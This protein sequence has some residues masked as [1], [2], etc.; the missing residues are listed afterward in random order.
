MKDI[1]LEVEQSQV[2]FVSAATLEDRLLYDD[3]FVD[4]FNVF[5]QL[6]VFGTA[7]RYERLDGYYLDTPSDISNDSELHQLVDEQGKFLQQ[8]AISLWIK[9]HRLPFFLRSRLFLEY[10]LCKLLLRKLSET[11]R[12]Q[13][14]RL[15]LRGY[16]SLSTPMVPPDSPEQWNDSPV[17]CASQASWPG[18]PQERHY[19]RPLGSAS[20]LPAMLSIALETRLKLLEG[21]PGKKMSNGDNDG[22]G[23]P[24][25]NSESYLSQDMFDDELNYAERWKIRSAGG[26]QVNSYRKRKSSLFTPSCETR[27]GNKRGR[28]VRR[29]RSAP[30]EGL[31]ER[32][33][34]EE[35]ESEIFLNDFSEVDENDT[36]LCFD[37]ADVERTEAELR[38]I[39]DESKRNLQEIKED[40]LNSSCGMREFREFLTGTSGLHLFNFWLDVEEYKDLGE[41][42]AENENTLQM[43]RVK[44]FREINDKYKTHLTGEAK[45]KIREALNHEGL[46]KDLFTR[47]QYDTLR[48]LRSYWIPRF[49]VHKEKTNDEMFSESSLESRQSDGATTL[50]FLPKISF[51]HSL[52]PRGEWCTELARRSCDWSKNL[53]LSDVKLQS[54]RKKRENTM[55]E[56]RENYGDFLTGLSCEK[57]AGWPFR[58][59]LERGKKKDELSNL[60]FWQ[61]I[62]DLKDEEIR[63]CDR[64]LHLCTAWN[65]VKRFLSN[66]SNE[67][68]I[69]MSELDKQKVIEKLRQSMEV[70]STLFTSGQTYAL[71]VLGTSWEEYL[72][73]EK[74]TLKKSAKMSVGERSTVSKNDSKLGSLYQSLFIPGKWY[75]RYPESSPSERQR[76]LH[77]AMT[78]AENIETTRMSLS[79]PL[80]STA[81]GEKKRSR[82]KSRTSEPPQSPEKTV[83]FKAKKEKPKILKERHDSVE[84][85]E[86]E[87]KEKTE[88]KP[89]PEFRNFLNDKNLMTSFKHYVQNV[90][91][92][93]SMNILAMYLDIETYKS[94]PSSSIVQ[95]TE[96]ASQIFKDYFNQ[97]SRKCVDLPARIPF[98]IE[99]ERPSTAILAETQDYLLPE[100]Q[101]S[102][103]QFYKSHK[104]LKP[105]VQ[106]EVHHAGTG[107]KTETPFTS[108]SFV[109]YYKRRRNKFKGAGR[110]QPTKDDKADFVNELRETYGVL[111]PRL[112]LFRRY[113]DTNDDVQ[114]ESVSKLEND[115]LFYLEVQKFKDLFLYMDDTTLLK[116]VDAIVD[117]FLDSATPPSVQIDISSDLAART[118]HKAQSIHARSKQSRDQRDCAVFDDAQNIVLKELLPFWAGFTR[119]YDAHSAEQEAEKLPPT[120]RQLTVKRRY[121]A[122]KKFP[123]K[124]RPVS[125]QSVLPSIGDS[126]R[127]LNYSLAQG[128]AWKESLS[129]GSGSIYSVNARSSGDNSRTSHIL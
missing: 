95:R 24:Q 59:F 89:P 18:K 55:G 73:D 46:T 116:K 108:N 63:G 49:L 20:S 113:L 102:F 111:S 127:E 78:I 19:R 39:I 99:D 3:V 28:T 58:D 38:S 109:V 62:E 40:A 97:S 114:G 90:E 30:V 110:L 76:R 41:S 120:R 9:E 16:S 23:E 92:S 124:K 87:A 45:Q 44:L 6:K 36:I 54:K 42:N 123:L 126:K 43:L 61:S 98:Q 84:A 115:L 47:T 70:S 60:L 104:L 4:Y 96:R 94:I 66:E 65:I 79:S 33:R 26:R 56:E 22:H 118:V 7:I 85:E 121:S 64:H 69:N 1:N 83:K 34:E 50:S 125:L 112:E 35:G 100:I 32:M 52:P 106:H 93:H 67:S 15:D 122:F 37:E 77:T 119:R 68:T 81:N 10:K 5:L 107:G 117:C 101:V 86:E 88:E 27:E 105:A 53:T 75:P 103:K 2:V 72:K 21:P 48:R 91:G 128:L 71:E 25:D 57:D 11:S 74:L 129:E 13:Q 31:G 14:S 51:V 29:T 12:V 17:D 8:G 80:K 82:L